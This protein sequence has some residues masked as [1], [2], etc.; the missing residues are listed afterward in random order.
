MNSSHCQRYIPTCYGCLIQ[1]GVKRIT[2]KIEPNLFFVISFFF[3]ILWIRWQNDTLRKRY[4]LQLT[5]GE[6]EYK[7][8][9]KLDA[10]LC[11]TFII[12]SS[13]SSHRNP[14][15]PSFKWK[16]LLDTHHNSHSQFFTSVT[17]FPEEIFELL[18][19][20]SV[21]FTRQTRSFWQ[22]HQGDKKNGG[23]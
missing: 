2:E 12:G 16:P 5:R 15:R 20:H 19:L 3:L 22:N 10:L 18:N 21:V 7:W 1:Q 4:M 14:K 13:F 9:W 23:Y 6:K 17:N 8:G 11:D